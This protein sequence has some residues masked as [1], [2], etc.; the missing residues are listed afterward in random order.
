MI[1]VK[2]TRRYCKD[3]ISKIENYQK[4]ISDE[5]HTWEI[6]HRRETDEGLSGKELLKRGEYWQRPA[7][8]LIFLRHD[9]HRRLHKF[10]NKYFLGKH[11]S[12]E[13]RKKM[14]QALSGEKNHFFGK[15]HS[16]ATRK[17]MSQAQ[18]GEKNPMFG[19]HLSAAHKKKLSA[20]KSGE[21]NPMFGCRWYNNGV[22]SVLARSCPPGFVKG[23]LHL[24]HRSIGSR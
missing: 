10:G 21:K 15:H 18:S 24:S 14:S 22:K 13:A 9:V 16:K 7:S 23:R 12:E 6:H 2:Q 1:D 8:E 17:K 19:K 11:H 20:A 4:A 3:D 5:T